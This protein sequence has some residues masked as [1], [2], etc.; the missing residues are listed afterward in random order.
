MRTIPLLFFNTRNEISFPPVIDVGICSDTILN[1][2][3]STQKL[4]QEVRIAQAL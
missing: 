3:S 2:L 4:A 1:F